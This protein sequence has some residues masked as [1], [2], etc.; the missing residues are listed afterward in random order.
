MSVNHGA[1]SGGIIGIYFRFFLMIKVCYVFLLESPHRCD[2][3]EYTQYTI[4][5]TKKE[6]Q[7]KL[8]QICSYG[9]FSMGIKNVFEIAVINEPSVFEALK[10]YSNW[11]K[12][13]GNLLLS[14]GRSKAVL[15]LC[16]RI[17]RPYT[18]ELQWAEY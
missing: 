8:S 18:V 5:N 17:I 11:I 4:F 13:S 7:P 1:R 15:L 10:F 9:F 16:F 2:F 12:P 6:N 14:T 3:N